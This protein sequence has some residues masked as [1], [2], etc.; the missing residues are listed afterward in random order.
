MLKF[1]QYKADEEEC[2]CGGDVDHCPMC[3]S[4]I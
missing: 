1:Y 2:A 4:G 3:T